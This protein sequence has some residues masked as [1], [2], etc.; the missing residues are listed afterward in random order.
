MV[1]PTFA[2]LDQH[3]D[4]FGCSVLLSFARDSRT[5]TRNL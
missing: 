1:K 3:L 2:E 4:P 5:A